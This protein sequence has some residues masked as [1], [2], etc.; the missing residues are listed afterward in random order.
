MP[1]CSRAPCYDYSNSRTSRSST[2]NA[3]GQYLLEDLLP[4]VNRVEAVIQGFKKFE[5]Q[6]PVEEVNPTTVDITLQLGSTKETV[7][8][9]AAHGP[10]PLQRVTLL[11]AQVADRQWRTIGTQAESK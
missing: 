11:A 6:V 1:G 2:S 4:G 8:V 9:A 3:A 7:L 10:A 5:Q